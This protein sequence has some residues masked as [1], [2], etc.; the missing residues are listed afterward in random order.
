MRLSHRRST[1]SPV[2]N[3][4]RRSCRIASIAYTTCR[5]ADPTDWRTSVVHGRRWLPPRPG[6]VTSAIVRHGEGPR[7]GPRKPRRSFHG[8]EGGNVFLF[9]TI[10]R[11][12]ELAR[13]QISNEFIPKKGIPSYPAEPRQNRPRTGR[14]C[15]LTHPETHGRGDR[16]PACV[17]CRGMRGRARRAKRK[18]PAAGHCR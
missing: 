6:M 16:T 1:Q 4:D 2:S 10:P 9:A 17:A 7:Q 12:G 11:G 14:L 15:V 18:R 5:L 8:R 13:P 3:A